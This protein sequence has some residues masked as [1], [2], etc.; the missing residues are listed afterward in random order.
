ML[1]V[2]GSRLCSRPNLGV[3]LLQEQFSPVFL[4]YVDCVHQLCEQFPSAF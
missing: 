1:R 4:Q 2:R 3:F